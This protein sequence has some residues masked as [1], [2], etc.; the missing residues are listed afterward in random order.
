MADERKLLILGASSFVGRRLWYLLGE[1]LAIGTYNNTAIPEGVYFNAL[2][3][4]I[5]DLGIDPN[6]VS[7]A[8]IFLGDTQPD[9]CSANVDKS[10]ALKR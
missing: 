2:T 9:S 10:N 1:H 7:A 3:M 4:G 6:K 8:V 5:A